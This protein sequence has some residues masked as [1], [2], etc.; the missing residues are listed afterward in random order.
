MPHLPYKHNH[1]LQKVGEAT[2]GQTVMDQVFTDG[3]ELISFVEIV[4]TFQGSD[5]TYLGFFILRKLKAER[6]QEN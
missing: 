5:P 4:R 6:L 2:E 1:I 3:Q